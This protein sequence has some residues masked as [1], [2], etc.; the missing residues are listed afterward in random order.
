M[1]EVEH[2]IDKAGWHSGRMDC[3]EE[4]VDM[5]AHWFSQYLTALRCTSKE[6]S[7]RALPV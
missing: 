3:R 1:E 5:H 6:L 2:A 4:P 7:I